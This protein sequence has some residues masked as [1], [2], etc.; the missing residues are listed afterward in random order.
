MSASTRRP[1]TSGPVRPPSSE[2]EKPQPVAEPAKPQPVAE[3]AIT[4]GRRASRARQRREQRRLELLDAAKLVF[5]EKGY[6]E[7]SVHEIIAQANV[8]RGTFYLYFKSKQ[9]LFQGL[10]DEFLALL[11]RNIRGITLSAESPPPLDQLLEN[12][13]RVVNVVFEHHEI[14]SIMLRDP[15]A[16]DGE[17]RQILD[18]FFLQVRKIMEGSLALGQKLGL[19][20]DCDLHV[21]SV[22]GLGGFRAVLAEALQARERGEKSPFADANRVAAELMRFFLEG[23]APPGLAASYRPSP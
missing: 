22:A 6:Y 11:R 1:P 15:S 17:S 13:R 8:A 9:Q 19:I 4:S 10:L 2:P 3:P 18:R 16:F 14:A 7:A 5:R 21:V 23:L 20:R 12:F